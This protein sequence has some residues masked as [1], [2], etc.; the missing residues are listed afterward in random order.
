MPEFDP[1]VRTF[2]EMGKEEGR[3]SS[4][5]RH[6]GLLEFARTQELILRFMPTG[7]LRILDVGGGP[8]IY[9]SWLTGLGHEVR[10]ID[11]VELH[12]EQ[13]KA[14]GLNADLGDARQLQQ[15][16]DSVDVVL[17][18]GPLYHLVSRADRVL[19]F[20]EALRVLRGGGL[21][22]AAAISRF[23]P[24]LDLVVRL[25]RFH[26]EPVARIVAASIESG[27]F[28]DASHGL[29]TTSYLHRPT[30]LR[31]EAEEAGLSGIRIFNVEGPGFMLRDFED[32]WADPGRRKALLAAARLVEEDPDFLAMASHLL[33]VSEKP[34]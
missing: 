4:I 1:E 32:R 7:Q 23:A 14:K 21:V 9:A 30:E 33:L 11:P 2:Y 13:A 18:L 28:G 24:L 31:A 27:L 12:V 29:F 17:L 26:E 19:A 25:D 22:F 6:S 20:S 15:D 8:G 34:G 16:A 5:D 3:L 10:L